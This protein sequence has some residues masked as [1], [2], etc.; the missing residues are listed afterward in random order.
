MSAGGSTDIPDRLLSAVRY[1]L[2]RLSHRWLLNGATISQKSSLTQSDHSV[3]Q[4]LMAY[5]G[6][7]QFAK[8]NNAHFD[9]ARSFLQLAN[10]DNG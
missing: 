4:V 8:P 5:R 9:L 3:R 7:G 10:L 2:A 1:A 6:A